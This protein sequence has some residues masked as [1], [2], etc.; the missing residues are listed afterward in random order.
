MS[1]R[2][3]I[4]HPRLTKIGFMAILLLM[5]LAGAA[6]AP[7]SRIDS[8]QNELNKAESDSVRIR[9]LFELS[10]AYQY[11]DFGKAKALVDEA[12]ALSENLN[13]DWARL[14]A[15]KQQSNLSAIR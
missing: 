3:E 14:R 9:T 7:T 15:Y 2:K 10:L 13:L 1:N 12:T 5:A 8:L 4:R 11:L 6:Q